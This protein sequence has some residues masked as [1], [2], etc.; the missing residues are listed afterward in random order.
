[1]AIIDLETGEETDQVP[2]KPENSTPQATPVAQQSGIID[3]DT[4]EFVTGTQQEVPQEQQLPAGTSMDAFIEPIKAIGASVISTPLIGLGGIAS[5][6]FKQ[7]AS[8]GGEFTKRALKS[9]QES[10]APQTQAGQ[11]GM[12]T[13]GDLIQGGIDI[14]NFPISGLAGLA[15]LLTG[16]GVE[17]AAS[18][19]ES[20]QEK[21]LGKTAGQRA[22]EVTNSPF[23]AA[24]VET[25]PD[26][27]LELAGFK[28]LRSARASTP[29]EVSRAVQ[30]S[31]ERDA[32]L[33]AADASDATGIDLFQAQQ[34]LNPTDIE[35]QSF[36]S[37]LP[38]GAVKAREQLGIQN[39]QALDAV[40]SILNQLAPAESVGDAAGK[41]RTAAQKSV[42]AIKYIRSEIASPIYSQAFRRQRQGKTGLIDT[43]QLQTKISEMSKQFDQNGQIA[44]NLNIALNKVQGAKGDLR[45][46]H[47][48]KLELD[49]TINSF[50]EGAVGNTTK[51]FLGDVVKDLTGELTTQSPSY[52][53]AKSEFQRLSPAVDKIQDSPIGK[54]SNFDDVQL[55]RVAQQMFDPSETNPKVIKQAK[56]IIESA[57]PDAWNTILRAELER[58]MGKI[59]ADLGDTANISAVENVPSQLFNSIFGNKKSRD[60]LFDSVS[61]ETKKNLKYLETALRRASKGR[62]GGSQTGIRSE[63]S[64]ELKG[65]IYQSLRDFIKS[66]IN[67]VAGVGEEAAFNS[68]VRA[69][70]DAMFDPTWKDD[71]KELRNLPPSSTK[72]RRIFDRVLSSA[73]IAAPTQEQQQEQ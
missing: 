2:V 1:M 63:I 42:D 26:A 71:M 51:R 29:R 48:A 73:L 46:L 36:V 25:L 38:E 60:V 5:S 67:T 8:Q 7:D 12:Q 35:R 34:T 39:K 9:V 27:A 17:Q 59:R 57:D 11:Q 32:A 18:T 6:I 72:A 28:G 56:E 66:P 3:L 24:T 33:I 19:V 55:K 37:Q 52:R 50:G 49:Q 65:G 62:P 44:K 58:R 43:K 40:D 70:S 61:G 53:A 23:V 45:K 22:L 14:V 10:V 16:Q 68:R 20:V 41:F 4:G 54:I 69:L 21:G 47:N 30:S 64:R 31:A 15:E 13:L